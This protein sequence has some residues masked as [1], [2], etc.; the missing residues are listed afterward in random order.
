MK[1]VKFAEFQKI[2][3]APKTWNEAVDGPCEGLPVAVHAGVVYSVWR[4]TLL[5]RL[6]L[7][8]GAKVRMAV[9][10]GTTQPPVWLDVIR[11][12]HV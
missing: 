11:I 9:Y 8:S 5:E 3:G 7:M 4:P 12:A 10:S 6:K 2:L 1:P